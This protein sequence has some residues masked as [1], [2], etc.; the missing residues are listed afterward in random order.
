MIEIFKKIGNFL[1][2]NW[3]VTLIFIIFVVIVLIKIYF[4]RR[5]KQIVETKKRI[6]GIIGTFITHP[7]R[8]S[9]NILFSII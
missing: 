7:D 5:K 8:R 9:R 2:K 4:S 6:K 1:A 3:L